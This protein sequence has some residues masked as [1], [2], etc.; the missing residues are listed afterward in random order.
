MAITSTGLGSGLDIEG[1]ITRLIAIESQPLTALS[2]R[3]A[4]FQAQ[5]TAYG[6][7]S[8]AVSTFQSAVSAISNSSSVNAATASSSDTAS[9]TASANSTATAGTYSIN[10][11]QLA[12]NQQLVATG[13]T[14]LTAS[15]GTGTLTFDFGTISGGAF[16]AGT[17]QYTGASFT[18][19]GN[20]I[21]TVTIS[22][23]NDSLTGI[24]DAINAA[25]IGVTA[26]II[27]DGS[28]TPYRL[29]L[30]SS[31]QGASNSIKVSVSPAAGGLDNFLSNDPAGVQH[32]QETVS[33]QDALVQINGINISSSSNTVSSTINGVTLNLLRTT[34][35]PVTV[36]V[37]RDASAFSR[38]V[39]S[40]V[41]AYNDLNK[42]IRDLTSYDPTTRVAGLLLGDSVV[43]T[44]QSQLRSVIN[45]T[46]PGLTTGSF[47]ALSDIG[48]TTQRD[49]SLVVDSSKFQSALSSNSTDVAALFTSIGRPTDTLINYVSSTSNTRNLSGPI[50]ITNVATQGVVTGS[51]P[52]GSTTI[53]AG[54]ND[55]LSVTVDGIT[56]SVTI[57][58]GVY[59]QAG[60]NSA[61]QSAING[62][63][64]IAAAGASVAVT[65]TAGTLTVTS[66]SYGSTSLAQIN[67]GNAATNLFGAV[68]AIGTAGTDVAGTIAGALATGSGQFLTSSDGLRIQVLGG[69]TGSRGSIE[70]TRGYGYLL[71]RLTS[72]YLGANG[73]IAGRTNGV[74]TSIGRLDAQR[75][76]INQRL[77]AT[78]RRL[79]AQFSSLDATV[80]SLNNTS[81]FLTQQLSAL[82]AS[83][84]QNNRR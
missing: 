18:S 47:R 31:N 19:N 73:S 79:R 84:Q 65:D 20:G 6:T 39:D 10:V 54:V 52:V 55:A 22:A 62:N 69:A 32:L 33:A 49:G 21:K 28:A 9:L 2:R 41:K 8:G 25:N 51:A 80:S 46:V 30:S 42:T 63:S 35:S 13:Q 70:F 17:G 43:R 26:T 15:I 44:I 82:T 23:A 27:N 16:N 67:G 50:N 45:N 71:D 81:T 61:I 36:T 75:A 12:K 24:R 56:A 38:Q 78:E 4:S 7:L 3:E 77:A 72:G 1:I 74:N 29:A 64:S 59:S 66:N 68:S 14:S 60:L 53:T 57:A 37:G 58:A 5:L 40:F 34:S 76:T 11:N 83:L 48:I